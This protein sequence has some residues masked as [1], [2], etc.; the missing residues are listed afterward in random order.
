M[1]VADLDGELLVPLR[2]LEEVLLSLA[3]W[4]DDDRAD[5]PPDGRPLTLPEP[6]ANGVALGA[7]QRLAA[8]L[9]PTQSLAP[10]A[11]RLL[12]PDGRYEHAPMTVLELPAEDIAIL[13]QT[14]A[15]LGHPRLDGDVADLVA[16]HAEQLGDAYRRANR[17]ELVSLT[18]RLAG[19]LDLAPTRDSELLVERLRACPPGVDLV[20][21][22][23][24][25][26]AYVRTADRMN[27][28]WA[29]GSGVDRYLY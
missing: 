2:A 4:E 28:I 8:A 9:R 29:L 5:P 15:T 14:A 16:T 13:S 20:L 18:A 7:V 19:L 27:H 3:G 26:Q 1:L 10:D 12:A 24:E 25:E 11:G 22:E 23:A 21:T 17:T 6:L